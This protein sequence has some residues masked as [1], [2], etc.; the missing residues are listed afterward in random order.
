MVHALWLLVPQQPWRIAVVWAVAV[1]LS[2]VQRT[3]AGYRSLR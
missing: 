1:F 2:A 3:W